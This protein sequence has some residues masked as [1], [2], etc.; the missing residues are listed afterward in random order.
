[1]IA[2]LVWN[3]YHGID[4]LNQAAAL[5]WDKEKTCFIGRLWLFTQQ[6]ADCGMN[7]F[8]PSSIQS[9]RKK[10]KRL[11]G[12]NTKASKPGEKHFVQFFALF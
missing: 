7:Y 2:R 1:M 12:S 6:S 10:I 11:C 5:N 3:W 8:S 9:W 4:D